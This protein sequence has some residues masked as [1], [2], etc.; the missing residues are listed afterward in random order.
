MNKLSEGF[1]KI[2]LKFKSFGKAVQIAIVV[3]IIAIIIAII[4]V[5]AIGASTKYKVLYSDLDATDAQ[6]VIAK[7]EEEKVQ[8]KIEGNTILVDAKRVDELR[9]SLAPSLTAGSSG[10]ELMNSGSTFGMTDEEFDIKKVIM[11]Q[12]ELERAIKSLEPVDNAKV[13]ISAAKD[14][15][16]IKNKEPGS[17]TVTIKLKPGYSIK[18]DQVK[19]IVALVSKSTDNIPSENVEVIDTNMNLLTKD[20]GK[21]DEGGAS[22]EAV[23]EHKKSEEEYE[24]K[25][26]ENIVTLLEP[27]VGKDKVKAQVNVDLDYDSKK[28]TDTQIDPTKAIISQDIKKEYSNDNGSALSESPVDNNMSNT[29]EEGTENTSSGSYHQTTNY[30]HSK[31]LT[32][33]IPAAGEVRRMTA[34]IFLDGNLDANTQE[35]FESAIKAA[36]GFD[37][38]RNDDFSLVG[39][40]FDPTVASEKQAAIDKLNEEMNKQKR[41]D[42]IKKIGVIGGALAILVIIAVVIISRRKKEEEKILDVMINDAMPQE[43]VNYEPIDFDNNDERTHK[44]SEIKKY[45]KE[46]PEQVADIIKSWLSENE[47]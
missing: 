8:M 29:I 30:E 40:S 35:A 43:M 23:L 32:E 45:A 38:N 33:T 36:I 13:L 17:A 20:I 28:I 31:T 44:E 39:I 4:S 15:V 42:L 5:I 1:K 34:S 11:I 26:I 12:G 6:T 7:L 18:A 24:D 10:Y 14:S 46:K 16:F 2:G 9:I 37:E 19:A 47:G 21:E 22:G 27:V 25:L 41:N 3:A